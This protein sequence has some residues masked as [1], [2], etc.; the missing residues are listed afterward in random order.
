MENI[1]AEALVPFLRWETYCTYGEAEKSHKETKLLIP[2]S[3]FCIFK[4]LKNLSVQF[5]RLSQEKSTAQTHVNAVKVSGTCI[6]FR[7]FIF[8]TWY[9]SLS[10]FNSRIKLLVKHVLLLILVCSIPIP[11]CDPI[12]QE[13][14]FQNR[15]ILPPSWIHCATSR[16]S[17]Q[18]YEWKSLSS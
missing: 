7:Q 13:H 8:L 15:E 2:I 1:F 16:L 18:L 9:W 4:T 11:V 5:R 17:V 3:D 14:L 10:S 6:S 12:R